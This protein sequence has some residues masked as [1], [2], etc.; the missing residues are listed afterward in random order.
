MP[1]NHANPLATV[2]T[3]K[4]VSNDKQF[5]TSAEKANKQLQNSQELA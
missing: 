3:E 2:A 4:D 5:S 1:T